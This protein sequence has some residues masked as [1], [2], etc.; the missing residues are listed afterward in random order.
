MKS[1]IDLIIYLGNFVGAVT[2]ILTACVYLN[3]N[4]EK[5]FKEVRRR[6]ANR[7]TAQEAP[8]TLI[9]NVGRYHV[10]LKKK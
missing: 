5:I 7:N 9:R 2:A 6:I 1:I 4:R 3:K 8:P 10:P